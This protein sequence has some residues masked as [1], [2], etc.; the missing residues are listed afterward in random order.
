MDKYYEI[1]KKS[2]GDYMRTLLPDV[3]KLHHIG[4][5]WF[6]DVCYMRFGMA[7]IMNVKNPI[8]GI[9]VECVIKYKGNYVSRV[10]SLGSDTIDELL[11]VIRTNI[12]VYYRDKI[13]D[14]IID[15]N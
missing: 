2:T 13:I 8:Y 10:M 6:N 9:V 3:E 11:H 1:I 14:S 15:G 12:S 5:I 7:F 4:G